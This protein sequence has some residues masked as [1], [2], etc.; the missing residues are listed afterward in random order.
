M[1]LHYD[2]WVIFIK[3]D[4]LT[5]RVCA[6]N[7]PQNPAR[8]TLLVNKSEKPPPGKAGSKAIAAIAVVTSLLQCVMA[9]MTCS[10]GPQIYRRAASA[11][12]A[13]TLLAAPAAY[14]VYTRA[15]LCAI[16]I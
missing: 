13:P 14:A 5:L 1:L 15:P 8:N 3:L 16:A 11:Q 2:L 10:I 4:E 9:L 12:K 7:Q 6:V